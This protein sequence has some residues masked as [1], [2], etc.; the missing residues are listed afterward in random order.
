V[1]KKITTE[2]IEEAA[3][4]ISSAT[5]KTPL[6]RTYNF[7]RRIGAAHPI[8]FKV[9]SLQHTGSF[10]VRGALNKLL[11]VLDR[12]KEHGIIAA[13]AGNHAQGVAYHAARLGVNAK[14]VMPLRSPHIKIDSTKQWGAQVVL[15]GESYQESYEK[16]LEIQKQENRELIHAFNDEAIIAGQGTVAKEV[17][18][19]LPSVEVFISPLGGGGLISGCG[20]YLKGKNPKAKIIAVQAEGCSSFLPSL[21]AGKPIMLKKINTIAEGMA[22]KSLGDLTFEICREVVDHCEL[23]SDEGIAEGMLWLLEHERLFVEGCAGA[24]VAALIKNPKLVTGPTVVLLSGGNLDVNLMARVIEQGMQ[25]SGRLVQFELTLQDTPGSLEKLTHIL[26]QE[27][28]GIIQI[29]HERI[30]GEATLREVFISVTLEASGFSH[31]ESIRQA[32]DAKGYKP[33]IGQLRAS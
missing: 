6:F 13:S 1:S 26:A 12:A 15:F 2:I 19:E 23:V 31:I 9:E 11:S 4:R 16:A 20:S 3:K 17:Y 25:K 32:L 33:K 5:R 30:F 28:A 7:E 10:K 8:Y 14:I 27:N 21:K 24:S 22:A 18:D 29:H